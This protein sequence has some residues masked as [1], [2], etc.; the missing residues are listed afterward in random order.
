ME[1]ASDTDPWSQ[2]RL[3]DLLIQ[4]AEAADAMNDVRGAVD[5][6]SQAIETGSELIEK[7]LLEE[8]S[9]IDLEAAVNILEGMLEI[10]RLP[11]TE[12]LM[13]LHHDLAGALVKV[14]KIEQAEKHLIRAMEIGIGHTASSLDD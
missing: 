13:T 1:L 14:G 6:C 3:L 4:S 8:N 11:D 10:H 12:V 9:A 2:N 5:R 7:G